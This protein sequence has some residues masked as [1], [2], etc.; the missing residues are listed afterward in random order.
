MSIFQC[1]LT[2]TLSAVSAD[3]SI[4]KDIDSK[5]VAAFL[6]NAWEGTAMRAKVDK[7]RTA[8]AAFEKVVFTALCQAKPTRALL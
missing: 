3:G 8:L 6:L 4:R 5:T 7:D 2:D 1:R